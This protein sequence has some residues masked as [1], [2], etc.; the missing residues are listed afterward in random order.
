MKVKELIKALADEDMDE[1]VV[2]VAED[3]SLDGYVAIDGIQ[4]S[5]Y[6]TRGVVRLSPDEKLVTEKVSDELIAKAKP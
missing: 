3:G 5:T 1:E 6:S 2:I 4:V